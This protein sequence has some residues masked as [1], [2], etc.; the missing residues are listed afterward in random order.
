MIINIKKLHH[1]GYSFTLN[2]NP[3]EHSHSKC[4]SHKLKNQVFPLFESLG[5][6]KLAEVA[7]GVDGTGDGAVY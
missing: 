7:P 2:V 1:S 4:L 6:S 3:K 5:M